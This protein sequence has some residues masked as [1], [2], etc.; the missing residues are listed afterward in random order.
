VRHLNPDARVVVRMFN[1]NLLP[2]LGK[3]VTNVVALST[4]AFTA[5]LLALTALT[6]DALGTFTLDDGRRQVA[7]V[8]VGDH[9]PLQGTPVGALVRDRGVV[10]LAHLTAAGAD[11]FLLDVDADAALRP[12]DRLVVCGEP[13]GVAPLLQDVGEEALPHLRWAGW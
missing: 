5:P 11:R 13:R 6:G 7:E 2:R 3:A 8:T 9:S 1:Q 4:S 10:V 12:G